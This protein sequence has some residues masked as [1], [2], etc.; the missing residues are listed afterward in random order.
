MQG[1]S[2]ALLEDYADRLDPIGQD[3]AHRIAAAA[4]YM[5]TLVQDL[6][7]Y[8]RLSRAEMAFQ[9]VGL[10]GVVQKALSLLVTDIQEKNAQVVVER[11]LPQVVGHQST[12]VQVIENLLSNAVKFVVPGVK[13]HVRVWAETPPTPLQ[14]GGRG[15]VHRPP[16]RG[17]RG[18]YVRLWVEDNGIGIAPEHHE[19][20]FRVLERLHGIETYPGTG[21]GLAIVRRGVERMGGR[22]GLESEA[23]LGSRFWVEL[24]TA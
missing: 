21:V 20:I 19:R 13:P 22:V 8:S 9:L 10:E 5:D 6:L 24:G 15:G 16:R 23:G 4:H 1:L 18:G 17:G 2:Q 14:E 11:P 7:T 12:L 3:Y